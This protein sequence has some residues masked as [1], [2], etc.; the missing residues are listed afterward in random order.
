MTK[1]KSG[2]SC[3]FLFLSFT[4]YGQ[5]FYGRVVDKETN[6]PVPF[7]EIYFPELHTGVYSDENGA[8]V[9]NDL[10]VTKLE[11]HISYLG[12]QTLRET[13]DLK[14]VHKKDFFLIKSLIRLEEVIISVPQ[15]GLQG[16][17]IVNVDS[18]KLELSRHPSVTLADAISDI[19]GVEQN[20]TGTGIGKPVIRGLSG[21]RIVTYAQGIRIENQQWGDEHGLG[22]PELGIEGVEV[23]KGPASLLYGA[24]ALG[25]VLYF[26]DEKYTQHNQVEGNAGS[27]FSSNSLGTYNQL[28]FKIHKN[29]LKINVFGG[30]SSNAD[31]MIPGGDRVLNTRFDAKSFKTSWGFNTKKWITN[32][33]YSFLQNDFGITEDA[34]YSGSASRKTQLPFQKVSQH[35]LSLDNTWYIG[36]SHLDLILGYGE[37]NRREFEDNKNTAILNMKLSTFTYNLKWLSAPVRDRLSIIAGLQGMNQ[38]NKNYGEERLIPDATTNDFGAFSIFNYKPGGFQFQAGLRVDFRNIDAKPFQSPEANFPQ[39]NK[40]YSSFNYSAGGVYARDK[41][42]LRL[43]LSSGYRTPNTSELLSNGI[44]EGTQRYEIG[45]TGLESEY[46][47]QFDFTVDFHTDH[48]RLSVNPFYNFINNYIFLMP[49]DSVIEGVPVYR[50]TQSSSKLYGGEAGIHIHPHAVHWLH[51]SSNISLVM[52]EDNDGN[53]LPLIPATRINSMLK[54]EL[55]TKGKFRITEV[56]IRDTY[57]F[58]QNRTGMLESPT[59]AYNL[60]D[61]GISMEILTGGKPLEISTG[62]KNLFNVRY[63]DHL[64]RLKTLNIPNPGINVYVGLKFGFLKK[65]GKA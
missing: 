32:L 15:G 25:G 26:I 37:N 33:H 36:D 57:K 54:A 18:K 19:P 47:N 24:D 51:I 39:F 53:P 62:I 42:T 28:N 45:N 58:A 50:Y 20:T 6:E 59:P 60:V 16:E 12:Y 56:F 63:I 5:Q 9:L 34:E 22:I 1:L 55:H 10:P 31:Y 11:I 61:I 49:V 4:L 21:S 29:G 13:V 40:T 46:S 64:S 7:A 17:N 23:I 35:T 14:T 41:I 8:F 30:Y 52:A 48:V 65:I 27:T 44:H 38:H 2:F 3:V 43:N